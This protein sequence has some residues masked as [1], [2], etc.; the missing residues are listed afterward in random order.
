LPPGSASTWGERANGKQAA[1]LAEIVYAGVGSATSGLAK[2]SVRLMSDEVMP[3]VDK[4]SALTSR[5]E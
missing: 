3:G 4:A 5:A 2:C 1:G